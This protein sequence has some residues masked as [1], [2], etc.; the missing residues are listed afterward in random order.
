MSFN[1]K[2]IADRVNHLDSKQDF[3]LQNIDIEKIVPSEKNFYG[4][5]DIEELMEDIKANGLYHNLVV[6]PFDDGR[7]KIISGERRYLALKKLGYKKA[8]CQVRENINAI[9]SE[10]M[11]IQ[12]NAKT[13]ELTNAEKMEQIERLK[14]LY[15]QKR[16][17]GE[18][19]EGKTRDLIGKDLNLSGSQVGKY[20]KINKDLVPELKEMFLKNNLDMSK[21]ASIASLEEPGQ[22]TI[23]ELLKGNAELNRDEVEKLKNEL[24]KKENELKRGQ[25]DYKKKLSAE[26]ERLKKA[27]E[28]LNEDYKKLEVQKGV[29]SEHHDI[30]D[31]EFN[32]EIN[33]AVR[34]LKDAANLLVRKLMS[35]REDKRTLSESNLK[36]I[37]DLQKSQLKYIFNF[38]R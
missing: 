35:V 4:M 36:E 8:P 19:L 32:L 20:Q 17:N 31:M 29:H 30:K 38:K 37:D 6:T 3:N 16:K 14:F 13:R 26:H 21:A 15:D 2:D 11:L 33:M 24:K 10:I 23:Y 18:K 9:D 12:A 5:R 27:R 34:N 7:Y 25:E 1:F 22:I 28:S